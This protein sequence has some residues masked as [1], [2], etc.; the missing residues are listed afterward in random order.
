[1]S[2]SLVHDRLTRLLLVGLVVFALGCAPDGPG[3][4][5]ATGP[6]GAK[7]ADELAE[8]IGDYM[9]PLDRGRLEIAAPKDWNWANPG[10]DVLVAFKP[11]NA[12]VNALPRVLLS[13]SDSEFPGIDDLTPDNI[14]VFEGLVADAVA[15]KKTRE[16][17][18]SV[19]IG[20]Q[21]FV[22]YVLWAKRRNQVVAQQVLQTVV[23]GRQY[24]L[25]LEA[26]QAH[27]DQQK[28]VLSVIAASMKFPQRDGASAPGPAA[29]EPVAKPKDEQTSTAPG[30]APEPADEAAPADAAD[31]E[32]E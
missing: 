9:P 18:S 30:D 17:V 1:M 28:V 20:G 22:R 27:F 8:R 14:K 11:K 3:D 2:M 15:D 7:P 16:P 23:G 29:E 4:K 25:Q 24:T 31:A 10:G 5:A 26:L 19:K 32:P 12:E 13:V 6:G 21:P